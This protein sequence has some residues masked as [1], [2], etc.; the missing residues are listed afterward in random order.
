MKY[1]VAAYEARRFPPCFARMTRELRRVHHLKHD[2]RF[3][4]TCFLRA[5]GAPPDFAVR[6]GDEWLTLRR[7]KD[8][9]YRVRHAYGLEGGLTPY[10]L[11][12]CDTMISRR[13]QSHDAPGAVHDCPFAYQG[14]RALRGHL[15]TDMR[16]DRTD[17]DA[18]LAGTRGPKARCR[19]TFE[20]VHGGAAAPEATWHTPMDWVTSSLG[21]EPLAHDPGPESDDDDDEVAGCEV[22]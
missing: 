14:P 10:S 12:K 11:M 17:V 9:A 2:A 21:H 16:L 18:V 4:F 20:A 7:P 15:E 6:L 3:Q 1:V 19:A 5:L 13:G 8:W 22:P